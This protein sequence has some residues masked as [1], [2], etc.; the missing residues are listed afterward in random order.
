MLNLLSIGYFVREVPDAEG[1]S[2]EE[3]EREMN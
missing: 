3:L 2:L 1:L